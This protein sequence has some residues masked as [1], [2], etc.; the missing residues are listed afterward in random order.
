MLFHSRTKLSV[1]IIAIAMNS[2]AVANAESEPKWPQPKTIRDILWVWGN[3]EMATGDDAKHTLATYAQASPARRAEMLGVNNII[4]AGHGL[5]NE[6][7]AAFSATEAVKHADRLAWEILPDA[8]KSGEYKHGNFEYTERVAL[9]NKLQPRYPQLQAILLDDMSSV[10]VRE[11]FK[12]EHLAALKKLLNN[13]FALWGVVYTHTLDIPGIDEY[14]KQLDVISLWTWNAKHLVNRE[15]HIE[16]FEKNFPGKPIHFGFY[17]YNFGGP[18]LMPRD[19]LELQG[20]MA[21]RL[22]HEGRIA[23]IVLLTIHNDPE[24]LQWTADWVKRVGDQPLSQRK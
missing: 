21:L 15:K 19:K 5:P 22:A 2:V 16:Y 14:I 11:G 9:L 6:E 13:D 18:G 3:P 4:M 7:K 12:P 1:F 8:A 20:E 10:A 23:G 17:L 24:T